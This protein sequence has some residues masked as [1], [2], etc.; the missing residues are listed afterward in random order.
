M[1]VA[2]E[3]GDNILSDSIEDAQFLVVSHIIRVYL[4]TLPHL[5]PRLRICFHF[6]DRN[7]F[8]RGN[9]RNAG[10]WDLCFFFN[11]SSLW[12]TVLREQSRN[13][14]CIGTSSL[15]PLNFSIELFVIV[16]LF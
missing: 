2:C 5:S 4:A 9:K 8:I 13:L 6:V 12:S 1:A 3:Q 11:N 7:S 15:R 16:P 14:F 10:V